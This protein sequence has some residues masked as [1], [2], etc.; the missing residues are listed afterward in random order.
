MENK[1]YI[2][3]EA[4]IICC[5]LEGELDIEESISL[6]RDLRRQASE[7]G[8]NVFYDAY[9]L[10][11]SA[12]IMPAYEFSIKLSSVIDISTH[13]TVRVAFLYKPGYDDEQWMLYEAVAVKRGFF[14]KIFT[15]KEEAL[16]WLSG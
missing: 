14:V 2:D 3:N 13:R 11:V 8:F 16:K 6:S 15:V 1:T 9:K 12:S 4:K 7:L 5:T 10:C